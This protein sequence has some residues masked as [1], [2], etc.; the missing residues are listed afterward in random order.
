[1]AREHNIDLRLVQGT[2]TGGRIT[3]Q[4]L[5][6]YLAQRAQAPPALE[7]PV[8]PSVTAPT[9]AGAKTR[10]EPMTLMR[11]K[12]AEHMLASKRISPHVTTIHKVDMTRVAKM[13]ERHKAEV[14][15][16]H[17]LALTYLPFITRA[18]AQALRAHP[19]VNASIEGS[20]VIYHNEINIGIA[21]ALE[22]GLIVPVIRNADEKNVLSLQRAI[23]DLAGRARSRQLKPDEVQ[24]GTF[25]ITNF[26]GYGSLFATPIINQPQVA[27]LGVG[28]VEKTPVVVDEDA[29]AIRSI[30]L[31]GLTFDHRLLDGALADQFMAKFKSVLENWAEEVL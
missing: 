4:D 16:R 15:A 1:M 6:A 28:A 10:L 14:Q 7:V 23:V 12:I 19:I 8:A 11:T 21:V 2:G 31:I 25:S 18:A 17:G 29:I 30:S 22:G 3:K 9:P 5:E 20:N 13:R 26:G 24:G 27:I